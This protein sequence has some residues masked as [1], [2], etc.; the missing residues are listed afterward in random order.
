MSE[1]LYFLL[2]I[3]P[4]EGMQFAYARDLALPPA[5]SAKLHIVPDKVMDKRVAAGMFDVAAV[6]MDQDV[7][8]RLKLKSL[9]KKTTQVEYCDIFWDWGGAQR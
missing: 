6:C 9:Y 3:D 8:E 1:P 7:V 5:E 4:P 2:H